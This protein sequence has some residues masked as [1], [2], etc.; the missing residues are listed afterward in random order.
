MCVFVCAFRSLSLC[1]SLS[2]SDKLYP[3]LL[4]YE[5]ICLYL[6]NKVVK[7]IIIYLPVVTT[8]IRHFL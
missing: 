5:I 2:V 4:F 6:H 1:K 3:Y 7:S 8:G